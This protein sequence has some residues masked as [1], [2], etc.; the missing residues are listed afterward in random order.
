VKK[1]QPRYLD[2]E[3]KRTALVE[4]T[5]ADMSAIFTEYLNPEMPPEEHTRSLEGMSRTMQTVINTILT[6]RSMLFVVAVPEDMCLPY[7]KE[8]ESAE[9]SVRIHA[10]LP[11]LSNGNSDDSS[12]FGVAAT[13]AVA[14]VRS[15]A[16]EFCES[17][18]PSQESLAPQEGKGMPPADSP[19]WKQ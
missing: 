13:M 6:P 12:A 19:V 15:A 2:H 11:F 18:R 14:V 4:R 1:K 9:Y 10:L 3:A 16:R 17:L 8:G 5:V 7:E